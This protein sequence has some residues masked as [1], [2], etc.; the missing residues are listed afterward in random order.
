M[1]KTKKEICKEILIQI[2]KSTDD[3]YEVSSKWRI[4]VNEFIDP[5]ISTCTETLSMLIHEADS[6]KPKY[7]IEWWLYEN[8]DHIEYGTDENGKE[9][10]LNLKEPDAFIDYLLAKD[11]DKFEIPSYHTGS[12]EYIWET[13][14]PNDDCPF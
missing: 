11:Y 14:F 3:A 13:V 9:T 8:V 2:K 1:A 12:A 7:D 4:D 5:L 6:L 10:Q